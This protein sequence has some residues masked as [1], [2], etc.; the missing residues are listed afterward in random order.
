M[1]ELAQVGDG[2]FEQEVLDAEGPVVVDFWA[3]WCGPCRIVS[4]ILADMADEH[5]SVRFVKLNVDENPATQARYNILSIP[6]VI[7]FDGG[8][9]REVVVGARSRSHYESAWERWLSPAA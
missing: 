2:D 3:P 9:A 5:V 4:P 1:A 8:E 7:L 6:T